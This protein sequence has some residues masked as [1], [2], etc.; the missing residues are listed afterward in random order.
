M[1]TGW[2]WTIWTAL[3]LVWIGVSLA[4]DMGANGLWIFMG[5]A[6]LLSV[7]P[8]LFGPEEERRNIRP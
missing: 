1:S 3:M 6:I 7:G 4:Y 5:G 8:K 2:I